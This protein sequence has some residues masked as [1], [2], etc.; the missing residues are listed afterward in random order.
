MSRRAVVLVLD[1]FGVGAAPDSSP[2]DAEMNTLRHI[3]DRVDL[4]LPALSSLG[5]SRLVPGALPPVAVSRAAYGFLMPVHPGA[6]TYMG[7]QE[8]MGGGLSMVELKLMSELSAAVTQA[9]ESA[10]HRVEA[11]IPGHSMLLVDGIAVVHDNIEARARLNVNVT[12]SLDDITF[13]DL[14]AIGKVVRQAIQVSRVIVVG[15]RGYDVAGIRAH[16]VERGAGHIGVDTPAL[17]VYNEHY[18]VRHLGL[19][20]PIERQLPTRVREAGGKVVLLGKAA[21][22]VRC[23][24]ATRE[25]LVP[26]S[27]VFDATLRHLDSME[28]GLVVANVQETDLAGHEQDPERYGRVLHAIDGRINELLGR[29][30]PDDCL[31]ITADHGN[32]PTSGS[33]RHTREFVP[34][35]AYSPAFDPVDLGIR[36]TLADVGATIADLLSLQAL[37]SGTSFAKE[38]RCLST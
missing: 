19:E 37:D 6:D 24:G 23:D 25:N 5:L 2:A 33:S 20:F 4:D 14:T 22:V 30:G 29:V 27:E 18:Q 13:D 38:I 26:T 8:L 36:S 1:G 34:V 28:D 12:A 17:G 15:S 9:L 11:L 21:D 31:F 7:H 16:I 3:A 32:D 10:G 35:L